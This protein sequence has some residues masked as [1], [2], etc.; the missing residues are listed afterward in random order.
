MVS[1]SNR[2]RSN[3]GP[4]IDQR[5][6]D[7]LGRMTSAVE[8]MQTMISNLLSLSRVSSQE[9]TPVTI[10]LNTVVSGVLDDLELGG[11]PP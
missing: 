7:Y 3:L 4:N 2:P 6:E 9:R 11:R 1:F 8:R 10:H 5:S